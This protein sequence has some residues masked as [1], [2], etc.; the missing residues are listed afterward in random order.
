MRTLQWILYAKRPLSTGELLQALA[1]EDNDVDIDRSAMTT[2]EDILY[3][4]SSLIRRRIGGGLEI[5]HFTFTVKE[6]LF[7]IGSLKTPHF[8][9]YVMI[10]ERASL[11]LARTCLSFLNSKAFSKLEP[12]DHDGLLRIVETNPF[13]TY[14]A[15]NWD[16]HSLL[17]QDD[18]TI[19]RLTQQ[20]FHPVITD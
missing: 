14:A 9:P 10:Q 20:L 2:E 18:E 17:H 8:S 11:Q 19:L 7:S 12:T 3:W 4:S 6:F 16:R 15:L 5:A 13:L 1:V